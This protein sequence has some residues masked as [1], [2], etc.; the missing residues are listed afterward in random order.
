MYTALKTIGQVAFLCILSVFSNYLVQ[1][2]HLP[3]PGS[4]V[5]IFILVLLLQTKIISIKQVELGA[6]LLLAELLLFFIPSAVGIIKYENLLEANGVRILLIIAAGTV[7][8]MASTGL[9]AKIIA[10]TR[11]KAFQDDTI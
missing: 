4:I 6:N 2:F 8:V 1:F 7:I 5:G 9:V 3:L 11:S 10:Y